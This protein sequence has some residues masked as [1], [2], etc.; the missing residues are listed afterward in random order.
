[1]GVNL[2]PKLDGF[3]IETTDFTRGKDDGSVEYGCIPEGNHTVL[4]F[5]LHCHNI[6]DTDLVVGN[7][8]SRPDIF[9]P[10]PKGEFPW[11]FK[12]KFNTCSIKNNSGVVLTG[13]K[14]AFCLEDEDG[15]KFN[16]ENQGISAGNHDT[17][18]RDLPCQFVVIDKLLDD[19]GKLPDGQY[20]FEATTNAPSVIAVKEHIGKVLFEEDNYDDNTVS[21]NLTIKFNP[22][23][24][25]Y[26]IVVG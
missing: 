13:Y 21:L 25:D 7:P 20:T 24:N 16:C 3:H 5:N 12:E 17:Y 14:R 22:T 4:R 1:M 6:G 10:G 23:T 8:A 18:P 15:I 26:Q 11:V 2:V 19:G 9:E